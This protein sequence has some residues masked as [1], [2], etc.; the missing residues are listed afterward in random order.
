MAVGVITGIRTERAGS[1]S[2]I[3][4]LDQVPWRK[5]SA[6]TLR[7]AGV[8]EGD[9]FEVAALTHLLDEA[10]DQAL[11]ERAIALLGYRD[12]SIAEMRKKLLEDGYPHGA[13]SD[14]VD[15]FVMSGLL[16]DE[17]FADSF[18]R[19]AAGSRALGR[20]RAMLDLASRGVPDEIA[21]A[22]LDEH[23]PRESEYEDARRA[24]IK[25]RR[26]GERADRLASRLV[27]KGFAPQTAYSVAKEL[28]SE[29]PEA[30]AQDDEGLS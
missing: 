6:A 22:A 5:T 19:S 14:I 7:L 9:S 15:R 11:R 18:V 12:R 28:A 20:R 1:R 8:R 26:P 4:E 24:A 13:V 29:A 2:R 25:I 23:M 3:V 10:E 17:R 27:R 30:C 16:D 21:Q